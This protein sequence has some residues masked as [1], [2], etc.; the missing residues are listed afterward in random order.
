MDSDNPYRLVYYGGHYQDPALPLVTLDYN[1]AYQFDQYSEAEKTKDRV[2][3]DTKDFYSLIL[4]RAEAYRPYPCPVCLQSIFEE[5][6]DHA[7]CPVCRWE[8]DGLQGY[9]H[10][11]WGGANHLS[12]NEARLEYFLLSHPFTAAKA[13]VLRLQYKEARSAVGIRMGQ[14]NQQEDKIRYDSLRDEHIA[15]RTGYMNK[16]TQLL[17]SLLGVM[18]EGTTDIIPPPGL[19]A[20]WLSRE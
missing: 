2:Y 6:G 1:K 16:L 8:N 4:A 19:L 15:R 5:E 18:P 12:V 3:Q 11:Y 9:N 17:L 20:Q 14:L 10:N 13:A 7:V